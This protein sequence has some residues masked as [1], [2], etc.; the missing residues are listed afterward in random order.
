MAARIWVAIWVLV[1]TIAMLAAEGVF[2][3]NYVTRFT[4]E[5]FAFLIAIVFFGDAFKK[6]I[7]VKENL[8]L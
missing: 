8:K 7:M 5:I 3:I 6:I 2:V 1:F 4:E